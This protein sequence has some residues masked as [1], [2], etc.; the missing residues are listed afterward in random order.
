MR[1]FINW[2]FAKTTPQSTDGPRTWRSFASGASVSWATASSRRPS[3]ATWVRSRGS[4]VARWSTT[5]GR[6]TSRS[7]RSQSATPSSWRT[8]WR[9]MWRSASKFNFILRTL[10]LVDN[11]LCCYVPCGFPLVTMWPI[12]PI[13]KK[14]GPVKP[15]KSHMHEKVLSCNMCFNFGAVRG[16]HLPLFMKGGRRRYLAISLCFPLNLHLVFIQA[17]LHSFP[18]SVIHCFILAFS[19]SFTISLSSCQMGIRALAT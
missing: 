13:V 8:C 17:Y 9:T 11:H 6:T 5:T 14:D 2:Y 15:S 4:S 18:H 1:R 12:F 19:Q 16:I 10:S 3:W 7:A